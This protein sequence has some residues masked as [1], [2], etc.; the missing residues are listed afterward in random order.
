MSH[1]T[2]RTLLDGA[3]MRFAVLL[4]LAGCAATIQPGPAPAPPVI[5]PAVTAAPETRV[6]VEIQSDNWNTCGRTQAGSLYCWGHN[7]LTPGRVLL[8]P[9]VAHAVPTKLDG[10]PPLAGFTM[11]ARGTL[12]GWEANGAV[13]FVGRDPS[14]ATERIDVYRKLPMLQRIPRTG[15]ALSPAAPASPRILSARGDCLVTVDHQLLC[16]MSQWTGL[17]GETYFAPVPLAV[18]RMGSGECA[19]DSDGY[20]NFVNL[21]DETYRVGTRTAAPYSPLRIEELGPVRDA[22]CLYRNTGKKEKRYDVCGIKADGSV[23]CTDASATALVTPLLD[24]HRAVAFVSNFAAL[25]VTRDD[26]Q[27]RCVALPAPGPTRPKPFDALATSLVGVDVS[28]GLVLAL[29]VICA[30]GGDGIAKCWATLGASSSAT[31]RRTSSRGRCISPRSTAP[32]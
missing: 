14:G 4:V 28:K 8:E 5:A 16:S 13:V 32:I 19:V 31:V 30:L 22:Y 11:T 27:A 9:V 1:T 6:F 21:R 26:N 24:D 10:V 18:D 15:E 17:Q 29:E 7:V 12:V 20:A 25:C 3:V 23:A 2:A